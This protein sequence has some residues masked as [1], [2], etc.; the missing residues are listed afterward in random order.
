MRIALASLA[1]LVVFLGLVAGGYIYINR[2]AA[3]I[4]KVPVMF[5][6]APAHA[7]SRPVPDAAR[8]QPARQR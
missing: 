7:A 4:G 6:P 5:A 1:A 2:V 3:G 8:S